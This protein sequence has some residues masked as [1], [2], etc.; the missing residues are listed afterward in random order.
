M[1]RIIGA[2]GFEVLQTW[3]DASYATHRD[4]KG[5][6]GGLM[7]LGHGIIYDKC[8]KQKLNTNSSTE[9]EVVGA[10]DYIGYTL[11]IKWFLKEQGYV[12]KHNIFYQDNMSAIKM[13]KNDRQSCGEKSTHIHI[14][15]ILVRMC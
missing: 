6:I 3:V 5:H 2:N 14:I 15:Y 1:P 12:L 8:S 7:S 10:S 13:E 4:M 9:S 11:Y